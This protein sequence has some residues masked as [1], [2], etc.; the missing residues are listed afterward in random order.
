MTFSSCPSSSPWLERFQVHI[1]LT[2]Y[3]SVLQ[4]CNLSD[5]SR[6]HLS[7]ERDAIPIYSIFRRSHWNLFQSSLKAIFFCLVFSLYPLRSDHISS[8]VIIFQLQFLG[9]IYLIF[10]SQSYV[11]SQARILLD[12]GAISWIYQVIVCDALSGRIR[13]QLFQIFFP[14][15]CYTGQ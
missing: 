15:S 11:S 14:S 13:F 9:R 12:M 6:S 5:S 1:Q 4:R 7:T 8:K 10:K 3:L 2:C